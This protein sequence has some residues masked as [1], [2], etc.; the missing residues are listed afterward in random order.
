MMSA[1]L[2]LKTLLIE[3][4]AAQ[5]SIARPCLLTCLVFAGPVKT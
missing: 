5:L 3:R 4:R 2:I 1:A